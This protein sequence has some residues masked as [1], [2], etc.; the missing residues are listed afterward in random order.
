MLEAA[1]R[2]FGTQRFHEVRMED[3]AAEAAVGKGTLY[4]YFSDKEELYSALLERASHQYM[5]RLEHAL[6]DATGPRQGLLAMAATTLDFFA[7]QPHVS[8]LIT[9]AETHSNPAHLLP[10]QQ[11]RDRVHQ[12]TLDLFAEARARGDFSIRDPEMAML[13]FLGGLRSVI[14]FGPR[15]QPSNLAERVVDCFLE[16]AEFPSNKAVAV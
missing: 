2:L 15:P 11:V 3:I 7:E 5:C 1:A 13:L 4:R 16:G 6:K 8:D 12:L 10:W 9:R 14:R